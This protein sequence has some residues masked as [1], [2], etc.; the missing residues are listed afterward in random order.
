[1]AVN[2][3]FGISVARHVGFKI[4]A[5]PT[6]SVSLNWAGIFYG[7]RYAKIVQQFENVTLS[8]K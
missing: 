8:D 7:N 1:M 4:K 6:M 2:N 3:S 5:I